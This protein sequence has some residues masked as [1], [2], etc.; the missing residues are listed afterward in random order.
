[1]TPPYR[2]LVLVT[3][4]FAAAILGTSGCTASGPVWVDDGANYTMKS[5]GEVLETADIARLSSRATTDAIVLR[6]DSLTALRKKGGSAAKAADLLTA[7]F[8][9]ETRAVPVYAESAMLDGKRVL[10]V[11]EAT[12]PKT[13]TLNMK[14][15]WVLGEDGSVILARSR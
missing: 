6:H 8:P 12:G 2:M 1:V 7:T 13:G 4:L 14:R 9:P 15:L 10:V 3:L 11:V 5:V